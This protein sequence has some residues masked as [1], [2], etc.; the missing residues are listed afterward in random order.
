M[1]SRTNNKMN[2]SISESKEYTTTRDAAII[3]ESRVGKLEVITENLI[4]EMRETARVIRE[5]SNSI[6]GFKEEIIAQLGQLTAPK[7]PL[8]SAFVAVGTTMLGLA[9]SLIFVVMSGISANVD[10]LDVSVKEL[11]QCVYKYDVGNTAKFGLLQG[12]I[13][14]LV[15]RTYQSK[16]IYEKDIA[17]SNTLPKP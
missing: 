6:S 12:Q 2:E 3:I 7:W 10:K 5:V 13:D 4:V 9:A 15:N 11:Q 8:I 17:P 16:N 1:L 14:V